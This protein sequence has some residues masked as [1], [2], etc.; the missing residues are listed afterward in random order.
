M[1]VAPSAAL[2]PR[3][4][5]CGLARACG[6]GNTQSL[7]IGRS[8]PASGEYWKG[9]IDDVRIWN[10]VRTPDEIGVNYRKEIAGAP[11][12]VGSWRFNEGVGNTAADSAGTPQNASLQGGAGFS[13]D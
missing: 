6:W 5:P 9:L 11:G 13:T 10:V 3:R 2:T 1:G 7:S 12:L 4:V 8:G